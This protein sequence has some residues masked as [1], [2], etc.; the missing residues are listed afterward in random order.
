MQEG[1]IVLLRFHGHGS[2]GWMGVS[3]G[4]GEL[5]CGNR[6]IEVGPGEGSTIELDNVDTVVSMLGA[7]GAWFAPFGSVELHGCST[8][9]GQEGRRLLR[10]LANALQVPVSA[11][12]ITQVGGGTE[13]TT[14]RFE[15]NA[16]FKSWVQCV[17]PEGNTLD[18]WARI[19]RE[20][21]KRVG[22]SV[23]L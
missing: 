7:L 6:K 16:R 9:A 5:K 10:R 13:K 2:P 3:A 11:G 22:V 23:P 12:T 20:T 17:F 15:V 8:G 19:Q 21:E 14:F 18:S 4:T 1:P